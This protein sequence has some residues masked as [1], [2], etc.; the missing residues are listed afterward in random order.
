MNN[1]MW[2]L[3]GFTSLPGSLINH[4]SSHDQQRVS[5]TTLFLCQVALALSS[6]MSHPIPN[7]LWATLLYF[8][9]RHSHQSYLIPWPTVSECH[10]F[11]SLPGRLIN[12]VILWSTASEW[13]YFVSFTGSDVSSHGQQQVSDTALFLSRQSHKSCL[14]PWPTVCEWHCCMSLPGSS[15]MSHPMTNRESVEFL[16]FFCKGVSSIISHPMT[17]SEWVAPLYFF[18]RWSHQACLIPWPT[19]SEWPGSLINHVLSHNQQY[20]SDTALFLCQAV[21]T[22][23]PWPTGCEW[24]CFIHLPDSLINHVSSMTNRKWVTLFYF[25]ARQ[26]HQLSI[27]SHPGMINSKWVVLLHFF[28]RQSHQSCLIPWPTASG[29]PGNLISHVSSHDQ[30]QFVSDTASF[31]CIIN[32]AS[33]DQQPVSDTAFFFAH[34]FTI[35]WPTG[36]KSYDISNNQFH[37]LLCYDQQS[38]SDMPFFPVFDAYEKQNV[39]ENAFSFQ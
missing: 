12:H 13:H 11:I 4:I 25:F 14:V 8:F 35:P 7:S 36:C 6:I 5:E 22:L 1:R 33:H 17:N 9:A 39:S 29:W 32:H 15:I 20:V 30:L 37:S 10:C 38:V 31:L 28:T 34:Y 27:M 21:I 2:V 19:G 3:H 23:I 16:Y 24:H 18:A 26:S